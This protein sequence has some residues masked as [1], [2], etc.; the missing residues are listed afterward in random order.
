[1]GVYERLGVRPVIN[2]TCH[3][4]AF[5]GSVMWPQVIDA[6]AEARHHC[7]DMRQLLDRAGEVLA[8]HTHA[9]AGHVVSGCAAGLQVGAAAVMT[10]ADPVK[11][12]ALPHA[13]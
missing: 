10:G 6:M 7:V 13:A 3:W 12:A 11:M 1:M 4:T 8:R 2:A 9:D 5:G